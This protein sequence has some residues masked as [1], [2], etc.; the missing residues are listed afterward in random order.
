MQRKWRENCVE[1]LNGIFAFAL[2][3]QGQEK[4]LMARYLFGVKP[5]FYKLTNH[6]HHIKK[7]EYI[8]D[9]SPPSTPINIDCT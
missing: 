7:C 3:E 4:L 2:W 6:F 5:L 9:E 8:F 1:K